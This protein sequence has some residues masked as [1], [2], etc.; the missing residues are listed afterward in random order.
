MIPPISIYTPLKFAEGVPRTDFS[1]SVGVFG[2]S[3]S[4]TYQA[5]GA[6]QP[7]AFFVSMRPPAW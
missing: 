6:D 3:E 1:S 7:S 4:S 5:D 2:A